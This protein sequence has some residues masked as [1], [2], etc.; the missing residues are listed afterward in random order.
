MSVGSTSSLNMIYR[1]FLQ[2]GDYVISEEYSFATAVETSHPMGCR[3]VGV[4]MD[5]EG[6]L[7]E[8]L[9]SILTNW[10]VEARGARKPFLVYTVPT[11]HNP[12]GST[13]STVR[14]KAV[15]KVAQKHD[16]VLIEDEPYYFL[17]MQPYVSGD[18]TPAP[19][20]KTNEEFIATLVPSLLSMDVDGRVIR[21][22]SFSKVLSPGARCGWI[23]A[24]QQVCERFQRHSEVSVQQPSGFTQVIF[25]RLLDEQWGHG[26]YLQWLLNLRVQYTAR[27]NALM[28]ACEKYLPREVASWTPPAAGMF[29]WISLDM[30]KY[31]TAKDA[32]SIENEV[33]QAL[34]D[35]GVLVTPGSY[36]LSEKDKP[37]EKVFFRATFA[38]AVDQPH[39]EK[40]R[41][42]APAVILKLRN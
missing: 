33:F 10:D 3:F 2:H 41:M 32:Q 26:G 28:A 25:H 18:S 27:R 34:L 16:L 13:L 1:M 5:E 24:S 21:L 11:G 29:H 20:P 9:D 40:L 7:P 23:V 42:G 6:M 37:L 31:P 15:Y 38:A 35:R 39:S 4:K 14:R 19:M 36:F 17:Q 30:A 12:T 22:D 8:S